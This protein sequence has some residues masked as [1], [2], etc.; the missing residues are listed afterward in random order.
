MK[1][2]PQMLN[3]KPDAERNPLQEISLNGIRKPRKAEVQP[4]AS[5]EAASKLF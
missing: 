1:K 2:I 4:S 5:G 3:Q